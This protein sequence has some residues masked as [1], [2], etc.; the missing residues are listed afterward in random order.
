MIV[1]GSYQ[2]NDGRYLLSLIKRRYKNCLIIVQEVLSFY[3]LLNQRIR[4]KRT[5]FV[6]IHPDFEFVSLEV[7]NIARLEGKEWERHTRRQTQLLLSQLSNI[8]GFIKIPEIYSSAASQDEKKRAL[9]LRFVFLLFLKCCV[10]WHLKLYQKRQKNKVNHFCRTALQN[11][12]FEQ[13]IS[14]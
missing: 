8:W 3:K 14:G 7:F 10:L 4:L 1:T 2:W 11:C 6:Y 5:T 9:L 13:I 12:T